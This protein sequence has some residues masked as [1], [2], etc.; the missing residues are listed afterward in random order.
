MMN[1]MLKK[2][3]KLLAAWI[4]ILSVNVG[5]TADIL[6]QSYS[7]KNPSDSD[8]P[9]ETNRGLLDRDLPENLPNPN[10]IPTS[11]NNVTESS[12]ENPFAPSVVR[13][14]PRRSS[15]SDIVKTLEN[16]NKFQTLI[17]ILELSDLSSDLEQ[18]GFFVIFAPTEEAFDRLTAGLYYRLILPENRSLLIEFI[19]NN[20]V[21]G[22]IQ[23]TDIT[24]GEIKTLS[25]NVVR[26]QVNST[27]AEVQLNEATAK[28]GEFILTQNG[29]IVP[30]DR[31]LFV[32]NVQI[33]NS[34]TQNP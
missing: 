14:T 17:S 21:I 15:P 28:S 12:N 13:G 7:E 29:L 1:F 30:I 26:V 9:S 33:E 25:G 31:V 4:V 5:I 27:Q 16:D 10:T 32:P 18:S 23:T 34:T 3:I 24:Q 20:F 11:E 2:T 8:T 22:Q 6:A 19:K